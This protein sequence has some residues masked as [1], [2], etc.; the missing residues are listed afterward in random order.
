[1]CL[2]F[3]PHNFFV[4]AQ[5]VIALCE[6]YDSYRKADIYRV[7]DD[8]NEILMFAKP[9]EENYSPLSEEMN[10]QLETPICYYP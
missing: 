7:K 9:L 8:I 10:K 3:I 4:D 2:S 6:K 1:M 5:T